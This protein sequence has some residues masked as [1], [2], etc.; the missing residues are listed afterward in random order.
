MS[1]SAYMNL[2]AKVTTIG[3]VGSHHS[4]V[5]RAVVRVALCATILVTGFLWIAPATAATFE[6]CDSLKIVYPNGVAK[7]Q[8]SA[9]DYGSF[10]SPD[11]YSLNGKRL[12]RDKDGIMCEPATKQ[13]STKVSSSTRDRNRRNEAKERLAP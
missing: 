8:R 5:S 4:H 12:D 3:F 1:P 11:L 2:L 7:D 10:V 6:N 9:A 13:K